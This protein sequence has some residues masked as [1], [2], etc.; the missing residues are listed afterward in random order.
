MPQ[1]AGI[2][3]RRG[4]R[5]SDERRLALSAATGA[6]ALL[7][8]LV[9]SLTLLDAWNKTSPPNEGVEPGRVSLAVSDGC[10]WGITARREISYAP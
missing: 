9:V 3:R 8:A 7:A 5:L 1:P 6:L 2:L 4:P 10:A